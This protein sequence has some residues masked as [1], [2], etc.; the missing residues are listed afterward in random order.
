[1]S[2][3]RNKVIGW[4]FAAAARWA[5]FR[6]AVR[7]FGRPQLGGLDHVTLPVRDLSEAERF[8]RDVLDATHFDTI[9]DA[10]L[11][12][13]GRPPA[14]NGGEGAH[15]VSLF[16]GNDVRVDLFLQRGG[17][18]TAHQGHP[19]YAFRVPPRA[20]LRWKARLEQAGVPTDGPVRLGPPG[21]ASL[22]FDDP[23]GNHLELVCLGFPTDL[24]IRPP[25]L[26]RVAR[27][28]T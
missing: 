5:R 9:D 25:D 19:H 21:H 14:P 20:L 10:A 12:R 22:Y 28:T 13:F 11:A 18:V 26:T 2:V 27:S 8:Y 7:R 3:V 17:Q 24:E 6:H 16:L 1:M 23:S 15:H 4:V